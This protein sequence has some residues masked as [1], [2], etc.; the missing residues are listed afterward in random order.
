MIEDGLRALRRT[1]LLDEIETSQRDIEPC[2][3]G[4]LEQH[5]FRRAIALIDLLETL[6]LPDAM[7][8]VDNVVANLQVAEVGKKRRDFRFLAL[9]ARRYQVRFVEQIARPKNRE[10]RIRQ[11]EA[12][13]EV[14][15]EQ[16][17][18]EHV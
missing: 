14:S 6:I 5:E 10:M 8:H 7:L 4:V 17:G 11:N 18:G 9:W 3:F 2:G 13:G 12:V 16:C 15:L 1:I